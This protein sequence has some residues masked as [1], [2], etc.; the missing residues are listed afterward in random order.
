M[1]IYEEEIYN[2]TDL[3]PSI[4]K[5]CV[6]QEML[7]HKISISRDL[8]QKVIANQSK[9]ILLFTDIKKIAGATVKINSLRKDIFIVND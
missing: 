1:K 2:S 9:T 4:L 6:K 7:S 8:S 3:V 5:E